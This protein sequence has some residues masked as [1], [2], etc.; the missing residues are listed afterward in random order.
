MNKR[1]KLIADFSDRLLTA[2][3]VEQ[4]AKVLG[5]IGRVGLSHRDL[6]SAIGTP[7][8]Y[9][10][11]ETMS[12]LRPKT[13]PVSRSGELAV[14][15]TLSGLAEQ[16]YSVIE[17]SYGT[18]F[19]KQLRPWRVVSGLK[20]GN[21]PADTAAK[22]IRESASSADRAGVARRSLAL[23][24]SVLASGNPRGQW[25]MVP[26]GTLGTQNAVKR[27][28]EPFVGY[29]DPKVNDVPVVAWATYPAAEAVG[30]PLVVRSEALATIVHQGAPLELTEGR[31]EIVGRATADRKFTI[32]QD[33]Y[34]ALAPDGANELAADKDFLELVYLSHGEG[35]SD[36]IVPAAG[37][38]VVEQQVRMHPR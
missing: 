31:G 20:G 32:R 9:I 36:A 25:E 3:S 6:H 13:A 14:V 11:D 1:D 2:T 17:R 8:G 5:Q 12:K 26:N 15:A 22:M 27:L 33:V 28:R 24:T 16:S 19:N 7:P 34:L 18:S 35:A 4:R 10:F 29:P 38:L 21:L 23:R 30:V 37:F